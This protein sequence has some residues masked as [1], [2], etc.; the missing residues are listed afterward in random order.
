[1][2]VIRTNK[3]SD[4]YVSIRSIFDLDIHTI[5]TFNILSYALQSKTRQFPNK[6]ALATVC[7]DAFATR[8][9][10]TLSAYGKQ[11]VMDYRIQYIRSDWIQDSTYEQKVKKIIDEMLFHPILDQEA[12][13]ESKY[14]LENRL[15]RQMD[16]PFHLTMKNALDQIN[17]DHSI[18]IPVHGRLEDIQNVT[19]KNVMSAYE[20]FKKKSKHVYVAGAI[21]RCMEDYLATI[22]DEMDIQSDFELLAS[23]QIFTS[24]QTKEISQTSIAQIYS[25]SIRVDSPLYFPLLVMNSIL[26]QSPNSLLFEEIREKYSYCYSIFSNIIRFDGALYIYT[27]SKKKYEKKVIA[28]IK[29]QI[30]RI[31]QGRFT[32]QQM[33]I[34]KKDLIDGFMQGQDS[35]FSM[36]EQ[37]YLDALM[38]RSANLEE[39]IKAI[40]NVKSGQVQAVARQLRL[41]SQAIVEEEDHK[42]I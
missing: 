22:D 26:G 14:L 36:I 39:R 30:H 40:Q 33:D 23:P 2:K 38:H 35:A 21:S 20:R 32:Q 12:I 41:V 5:T 28:L 13:D 17:V 8:A 31:S 34:A 27:G 11:A 3:F 25:T 37:S 19:L 6:Q 29:E 18:T 10:F 7:S 16:D 9:G 24:T 42:K 1:M 4:V 15:L